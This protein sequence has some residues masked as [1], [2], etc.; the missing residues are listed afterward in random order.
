MHHQSPAA[1]SLAGHIAIYSPAGWQPTAF[2]GYT[3][4]SSS[5]SSAISTIRWTRKASVRS[6]SMKT[7]SSDIRVTSSAKSAC[8]PLMWARCCGCS[9]FYA[10]KASRPSARSKRFRRRGRR[11]SKISGATCRK[12]AVL[13][14]DRSALCCRCGAFSRAEISG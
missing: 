12:S 5:G 11:C 7:S 2:L 6:K 13:P 3:A 14:R 10:S 4:E 1:G 9:S 8:V